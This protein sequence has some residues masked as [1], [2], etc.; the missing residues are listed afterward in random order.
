MR[1]RGNSVCMNGVRES[2]VA[3]LVPHH[4]L[5]SSLFLTVFDPL[6]QILSRSSNVLGAD[7]QG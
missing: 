2:L 7:M 5:V 3:F 6:V 1:L 4:E